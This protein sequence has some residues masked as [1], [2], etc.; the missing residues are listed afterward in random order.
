MNITVTTAS[1]L[2]NTDFNLHVSMDVKRNPNFVIIGQPVRATPNQEL[3]SIYVEK[4]QNGGHNSQK[5]LRVP[6]L[7]Q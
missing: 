2:Q 4:I 7:L 5:V 3:P 1:L 6:F